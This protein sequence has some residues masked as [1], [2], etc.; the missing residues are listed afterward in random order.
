MKVT[1]LGT[2]TSVGVP[3]IG[4]DCAVCRSDD[5]KNKR[6]RCSILLQRG[7]YSILVDTTP[8]LRTQALRHD[9]KRVDAVLFTHA[10]ADHLHGLD[11]VR[12]YCFGRETPLPCH[13]SPATLKRIKHVFDYAFDSPY[14]QAVPQ[15]S[16]HPIEGPFS[17]LGFEIEP[18]E[19]MHGRLPVLGFRL[20]GFAY[21]TDCSAIPP[22]SL[23]RLRGLDTLVIDGLRHKPHPTHF[24][25][26]QALDAVAELAPKHA[27]L[28]HI[29]CQLEHHETNRAL[30]DGVE[31][32]YDG[33]E[34]DFALI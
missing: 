26:Q 34:L 23:E 4:C 29:S 20:G 19:V 31:M 32:A 17:L 1:F 5:P 25:V 21:V 14:K 30:P 12:C 33:L 7:D 2:G 28:T 16:L 27:Y 22:D 15:L 18:I 3:R 10:H 24:T 9:I 6:L 13:A 11:E 8:D